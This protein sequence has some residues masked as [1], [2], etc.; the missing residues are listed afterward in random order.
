MNRRRPPPAPP[1]VM[2]I[3]GAGGDLTKRKLLPSLYN[4]STSG[5]L[6]ERF[7]VIAVDRREMTSEDF[8]DRMSEEIR[9]N[10]GGEFAQD[11]WDNLGK[12]SR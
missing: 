6:P 7:A 12:G 4:L 9:N 10:V 1:C 11:D 2:V 8:R 5:L 3:F